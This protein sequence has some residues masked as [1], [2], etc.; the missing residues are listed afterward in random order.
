MNVLWKK[1]L[2]Y[3]E[4]LDGTFRFLKRR[5]GMI[6]LFSLAISLFFNIF[7]EWWSWDLFHPDIG[8]ANPNG[9]AVNKIIMFFLIKGLVWF[10]S[11]YPLLQILAIILVQ[12]T[13]QSFSQT[14]KN[15]WTH[16]G[17]AI[18]AHGIALIGWVVIFF[19]FFSIIGLPSYLIFQAESFLS[20]EA[21][22]WTGLYTTLFFFFGP[23]LLLFIRFSLVIP[24][25][26]TGNAQLKDVFKKSWFLTKGSTFKVFG[27]IFG[28]VIISMIVKTLNVVITFLPDLFGA[29]TTLIWEM[30]FTI[31]IFLVDASI[32][33]LIPIY[34]AIF[35]FNELIRKEALDIQIQLKQIVPDRR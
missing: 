10:I 27:G 25:L 20:Q 22:F 12:D 33:P 3:G 1:P 15:I 17:K 2:K 35:Y 9:D 8:G 4:L 30:I 16:S 19:I 7:L 24:L 6:W 26:V 13:E 5:L 11:L 18:L 29:S 28:L 32:I 31:L 14:I 34:F 23:A 21:A